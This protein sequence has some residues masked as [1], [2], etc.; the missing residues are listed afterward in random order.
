KDAKTISSINLHKHV[1]K[2]VAI[3][4]AKAAS[5][6]VTTKRGEQTLMLNISDHYGMMDVVVWPEQYRRFYPTLHNS[7]ALRIT[8]KVAESFGVVTLVAASIERV[9]F[10]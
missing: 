2:R 10:S 8:G 1:R 7:E 3:Q 5:K 6:R 9:D 4:G